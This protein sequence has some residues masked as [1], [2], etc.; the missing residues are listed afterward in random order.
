LFR[1][2]WGGSSLTCIKA[3]QILIIVIKNIGS[4]DKGI[5]QAILKIGKST[6]KAKY[7]EA[8]QYKGNRINLTNCPLKVVNTFTPSASCNS[9]SPGR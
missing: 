6:D 4:I 9:K 2:R 5:I 8:Q 3:D 7:G 1:L